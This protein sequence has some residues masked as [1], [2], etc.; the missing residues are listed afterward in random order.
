[1]KWLRKNVMS[2][3]HEQMH[4]ENI[5]LNLPNEKGMHYNIFIHIDIYGTNWF[6]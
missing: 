2:S 4:H 6:E 5:V 3:L 1:M